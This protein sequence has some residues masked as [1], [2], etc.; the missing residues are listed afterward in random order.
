MKKLLLIAAL[1]VLSFSAHA[2][3]YSG[4]M[5]FTPLAPDMTES[6]IDET[7]AFIGENATLIAHHL[8][9]GV[10]WP[11]ALAGEPFPPHM[12]DNWAKRKEKTPA[13]LKTFL[14]LTPISDNRNGL[15]QYWGE[16]ER[17]PLP[18]DWPKKNFN[19]E[20][21]KKAY[22]YYV[23]QAVDYFHPDFLAIGIES[24]MLVSKARGRWNDYV[25]LN[26]YI[27]DEVKRLHPDLP[28]FSTVQ[29]E[30]MRGLLSDSKENAQYQ[31]DAVKELLKHSDYLALSTY[32]STSMLDI[33][34]EDYFG[35]ALA[36]G[37]PVAIAESGANS[38]PIT[39]AGQEY[40][41]TEEDQVKFVSDILNNAAKHKFPFVVNFVPIDFDALM[42]KLPE[43]MD[44]ANIWV[45]NGLLDSNHKAKPALA[46]WRQHLGKEGVQ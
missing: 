14:A 31:N 43:G 21:V 26:S 12:M 16:K 35:A 9:D 25:E 33:Q 13:G 42:K 20:D 1:F 27:Y 29:Y 46:V 5:G 40:P 45:H 11:E 8:D 24:N 41:A 17:M 44:I 3:N 34:G 2:E 19:D 39:V 30:H 37:K 22:L 15:A 32:K 38:K 7:Y 36:F 28:I 18:G 10:P 23:L 6:A 4:P